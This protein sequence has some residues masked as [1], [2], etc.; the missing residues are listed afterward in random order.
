MEIVILISIAVGVLA[1]VFGSPLTSPR[2]LDAESEKL[3]NEVVAFASSDEAK[4]IQ[5]EAA[6]AAAVEMQEK[7]LLLIVQKI[8]LKNNISELEAM[9]I[10]TSQIESIEQRLIKSGVSEN[11]VSVRILQELLNLYKTA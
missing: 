10:L 1:F 4:K 2:K 3:V 9:A 5:N 8:M 11:E 6:V 7:A